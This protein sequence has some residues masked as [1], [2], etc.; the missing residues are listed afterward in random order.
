MYYITRDHEFGMK[1]YL[2]FT[3]H[4]HYVWTSDK[5]KSC[6]FP[7][8]NLAKLYAHIN[9]GSIKEFDPIESWLLNFS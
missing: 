5:N 9:G 6:V 8:K 7:R 1:M 4:G 2:C 3:E